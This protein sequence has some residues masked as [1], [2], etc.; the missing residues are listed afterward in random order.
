MSYLRRN[1]RVATLRIADR[2]EAEVLPEDEHNAGAPPMRKGESDHSHTIENLA[3]SLLS[4]LAHR[5]D[6][7]VISFAQRDANLASDSDV[8]RVRRMNDHAEPRLTRHDPDGV[9]RW[10]V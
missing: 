7:H 2:G 10:P 5:D 9:L 4:R 3:G 1:M 6:F 8:A